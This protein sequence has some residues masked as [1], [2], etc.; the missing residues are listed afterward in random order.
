MRRIVRNVEVQR[1]G[2]CG[3]RRD[4]GARSGRVVH[5]EVGARKEDEPVE[6]TARD[7]FELERKT[8]SV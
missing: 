4:D 6:E 3:K 2:E 5:R 7:K 1:R 8:E